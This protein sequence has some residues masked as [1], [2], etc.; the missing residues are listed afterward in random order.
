MLNIKTTKITSTVIAAVMGLSI[1]GSSVTAEAAH[2]P[3]PN[4][5]P[6]MEQPHKSPSHGHG[7]APAIHRDRPPVHAPHRNPPPRYHHDDDRGYSE[8]ER[9]TAGIVGL[10]IGAV[11]GSAIA[12]KG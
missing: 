9:N 10:V 4:H 8:G 12:N 5:P 11:I 1:I 3:G 6:R 2:G 7:P